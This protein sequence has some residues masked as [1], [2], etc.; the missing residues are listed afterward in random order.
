M[1]NQKRFLLKPIVTALAVTLAAT[2]YA[3]P[4]NATVKPFSEQD[5]VTY[6]GW[7]NPAMAHIAVTSGRALI[8]HLMTARALLDTSQYDQ[9]RSALVASKEFADAI[10][11]IMPYLT[12]AEELRNTSDKLVEEK[13]DVLPTDLLPIYASLDEMAVFAPEAAHKST[14]MVKQAQ[15]HAEAGDKARAAKELKEA[16][17][18][19][20]QHTV[21]LPVDY[22]DQQVRVAQH[23]LDQKQPDVK[24]AKTAVEHAVHSLIVVVDAVEQTASS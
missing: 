15:K 4:V 2:T 5:S 1:K 19:V 18:E 11:R 22:V 20:A 21:Y 24:T 3:M 23:A 17:A 7:G 13:V 14:D 6:S 16:A 9:A 10:Q 12:V 8:D